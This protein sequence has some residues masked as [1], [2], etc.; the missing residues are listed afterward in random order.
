MGRTAITRLLGHRFIVVTGKGGV[1]KSAIAASLGRA[2]AE[3]GQRT[4]VLEVDP[5]ENVHQLLEVAPSGGAVVRVGGG[6][7]LQNLKPRQALDDLIRRQLG[8]GIVAR[9]VLKSETYNQLAEGAP[10][11]REL[12]VLEYAHSRTRERGED[13][14]GPFDTVILDAPATG[15]GVSLL[16][17]PLLVSEVVAQGPVGRKARELVDFVA[18]PKRAAVLIVTQA[19]EMPVQEA[20]ELRLTLREKLRRD[21]DLLIVNGLY[22]PLPSDLVP[23]GKRAET[24]GGGEEAVVVWHRRRRVNERELARLT[25]EWGAPRVELPL[26]PLDRGPE[27]VKALKGLI[28]TASL[29]EAVR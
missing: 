16:A 28:E 3:R 23:K 6:L 19:E 27:L 11:L 14:L 9:R 8:I 5:R 20:L 1:G 2:L 22:P 4:L 21:P 18:D 25:Q 26:L 29:E 15:H 10:G 7:F 12:G 24:G 17:A 13:R